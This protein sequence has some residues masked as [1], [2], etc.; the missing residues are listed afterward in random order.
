MFSIEVELLAGRYTATSAFDYGQP[1]WPPHPDRLFSALYCAYA[2]GPFGDAERD[3]LLWMESLAPPALAASDA[4]RR[5][6]PK[7]YVPPNDA[8]D[9]EAV[10]DFRTTKAPRRFPTVIPD[11]RIVHFVWDP[12][13][14]QDIERHREALQR[15]GEHVQYLGHSSTPVRVTVADFDGDVTYEPDPSGTIPIRVPRPGR[16]EELEYRYSID[17][18]P[19]PSA[20]ASYVK[21]DEQKD[22]DIPTSCFS[23][24]VVFRREEGPRFPLEGAYK[25]T[26][27][28][29][30]AVM[31][32]AE[33]PV[34]PI[35]T[36]HTEDGT[37]LQGDHIAY[38]PMANVDHRHAD[39]AVLGFAL[40][41]PEETTPDQ[42]R[43]V[44]RALERHTAEGEDVLDTLRF[45]DT[46]NLQVSRTPVPT[47]KS[48]QPKTYKGPA[49]QWATMTPMVYDRFPK[50]KDG[51]RKKDIIIRACKRIGLPQ[52]Q[53]IGF[54]THSPLDG[55]P[56]S[57][58]FFV[59]PKAS[60]A[61]RPRT[62]VVLAFEEPVRGP[63]VLG[64]GRYFGLGVMRPCDGDS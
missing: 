14:S 19:V 1:E 31:S 58:E 50:D 34:R 48:L 42:R 56:P 57:T 46:A 37:P 41:M 51:D 63:V 3:A 64:A 12:R 40:L 43:Y 44:Y 47:R 62:H 32:R 60:F 26:S 2:E 61:N 15:L 9:L 49:R 39:G 8:S 5:E 53:S 25:L 33:D 29:R 11:E 13:N 38:I 24:M 52:P 45:R 30:A 55:V 18:R 22:S 28:V 10:P 21:T 4:V 54:D 20:S 59:S 16:L 36:G 23:E 27:K 17:E 6:T 35:I 7:S